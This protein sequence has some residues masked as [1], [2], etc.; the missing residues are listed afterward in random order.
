MTVGQ[1]LILPGVQS[2]TT[3]LGPVLTI[4]GLDGIGVD[5]Q[6]GVSGF[7]LF[8]ALGGS[9]T[10]RSAGTG[11]FWASGSATFIDV[12]SYDLTLDIQNAA[13]I[14]RFGQFR[15]SETFSRR[16]PAPSS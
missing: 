13:G 7:N 5:D 14:G 11:A 1:V 4:N 3:F 15:G 10:W 12:K 16:V 2:W 8:V 6:A 9:Q